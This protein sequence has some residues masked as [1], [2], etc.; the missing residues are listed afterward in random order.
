MTLGR[1]NRHREGLCAL[2]LRILGPGGN[3]GRG[4]EARFV[5]VTEVLC[6]VTEMCLRRLVNSINPR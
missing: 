2:V 5:G 4:R 6:T 3:I 1:L